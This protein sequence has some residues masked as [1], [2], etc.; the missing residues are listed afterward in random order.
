MNE[1]QSGSI[2][3]WAE[4]DR[5]REKLIRL[6]KRNLSDSELL[7]ILIGSG[8]KRFS[9]LDLARRLLEAHRGDLNELARSSINDLV[10]VPG[11]G[12]ARAVTI[13]AA[14]ELGNRRKRQEA[15]VVCISK[16]SDAFKH[17]QPILGD[18]RHEEFWTLYLNRKNRIIGEKQVSQGGLSATVVDP[19]II[20]RHAIELGASALILVHNHPSE[21]L[22]PSQA[23][24][25]ITRKI[26]EGG[27]QLDLQV[28]DHLIVTQNGY[29]SFNDE[30]W[31]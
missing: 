21:N 31:L 10:K 23:D 13:S 24:L 15:E 26:R 3:C 11:I 20:F 25:E 6:G 1:E 19:R 7:A 8:T 18:L 29:L 30:G 9:A 22:K 2:K 27:Q 12:L 14:I 16:S 5:P 17:M 28:L 4:D